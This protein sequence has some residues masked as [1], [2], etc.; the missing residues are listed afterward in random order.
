[1]DFKQWYHIGTQTT[2]PGGE[3]P[4]FFPLPPTT[5]GAGPAPA[6][7]GTPT[8]VHKAS[9]GGKDWMQVGTYTAGPPK[10]LGKW[11][12]TTGVPRVDAI[13]D[14]GDLYASKVGR[15]ATSSCTHVDPCGPLR[16]GGERKRL[17][18]SHPHPTAHLA[19]WPCHTEPTRTGW[20]GSPR[21]PRPRRPCLTGSLF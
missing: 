10:V 20:L 3:C 15:V 12:D 4:S 6:G 17:S 21:L 5:P 7:V 19:I 13:I 9:H 16:A 8:H 18:P 11:E 2:F 1:M 14:V